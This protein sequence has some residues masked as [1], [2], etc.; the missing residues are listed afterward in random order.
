MLNSRIPAMRNQ[1]LIGLGIFIFGL[2]A[3]WQ[4][5]DKIAVDD[6]RSLIFV[7]LGFAACAVAVAILRNWR[8]GFYFFLI[9][10]LFEDLVRKYLANGTEL[11][12]GKDI[13]LALVYVALYVEIRKGREKSFRP[14]FLFFLSIFVWLGVFQVFNQNSPHIL[15]GLLGFKVDFYYIPLI[16]VGYALVRGDGDLRKFLVV[17]AVLAGVIGSLGII[18]AILGNKFL[19]PAVLAPELADLGDFQRFPR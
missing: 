12:F 5:G 16:F 11:F 17:N 18:Q 2:W 13:L 7:A 10:L 1:A 15:Y 19:N 3:V 6:T 9:W 8:N 4:V 14:P